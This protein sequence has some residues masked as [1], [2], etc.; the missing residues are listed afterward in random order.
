MRIALCV[1]IV[2]IAAHY[3]PSSSMLSG[4][5]YVLDY[6]ANIH[7]DIELVSDPWNVEFTQL[8]PTLSMWNLTRE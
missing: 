7:S 3:Q 4:E 6:L 1:V 8:T 5:P 2:D